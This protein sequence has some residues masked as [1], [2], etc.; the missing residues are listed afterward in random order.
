[1]TAIAA[2]IGGLTGWRRHGC[3][4]VLGLIA[5][6]ALPPAGLWPFLFLAFPPLLWLIDGAP[7]ARTAFAAGWWF[8]FGYLVAGL[9]WLAYP[10]LIEP[11]RFAWMI[12]FSVGGL[13]AALAIFMGLATLVTWLAVAPGWRRVLVFGIAWTGFEWLRGTILTGFPWNLIGYAW[14]ENLAV[15]QVAAVVGV[16][17]LSLVTLW[18]VAMPATLA[19]QSAPRRTTRWMPAGVA[20]VLF[21][22]AW[23]G[24]AW[25]LDALP[26]VLLEDVKLRL[27]QANVTQKL[28]WEPGQRE[29]N[30]LRHVVL[31]RKE[32]AAPNLIIWPETASTFQIDNGNAMQ[33][34]TADG[35]V[36]ATYDKHHLVPFGEYLPLRPVLRRLGMEQLAQGGID[37]SAGDGPQTISLPG[38][39]PFSPLICYEAIFPA[40]VVDYDQRPAWL[41]SLTNDAW[42]GPGAGPWQHFQMARMRA[43]EQGLPMVRAANTGISGVIDP[44]GRILS[45]LEINTEGVLDAALPMAVEHLPP[46]AR[47]GDLI[48]FSLGLAGLLVVWLSGWRRLST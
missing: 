36:T 27:V 3:A 30:L 19:A 10:M 4:L 33:A 8:G 42:F 41:L 26:T 18:V 20:L 7:R 34:V 39:P 46:Y 25:R 17:G 44:A 21:A 40:G 5:A 48:V 9:H 29:A 22:A 24:G 13:P 6:G 12:P 15:M 35:M 37:F 47:F 2:V 31:S 1:M 11:D 23:I 28:K 45:Y 16:Y 43:V 14:S 38:A 32:G